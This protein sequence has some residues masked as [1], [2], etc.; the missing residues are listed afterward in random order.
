MVLVLANGQGWVHTGSINGSENSVKQNREMA[1]QVQSHQAFDDLS[2]V[3]WWDWVASGG[4]VA[5]PPQEVFLP[6]VTR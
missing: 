6:L 2:Q 3:F 4:A 5:P 1:V